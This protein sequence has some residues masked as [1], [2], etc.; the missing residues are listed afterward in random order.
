MNF[1]ILKSAVFGVL[2]M[3]VAGSLFAADWYV[4]P[5]GKNKA[6]GN[7]PAAPFKNIWKAIDKAKPGDTIRIAEGKYFGKMQCGWIAVNKPVNLIGGYSADFKTRNPLVHKTMLQPT[8]DM[9]ATKPIFG[10]LTI[11][12]TGQKGNVVVD[13]FVFDHTLANSY[14]PTKGK[15]AGFKNGMWLQPPAKGNTKFPSIDRYMLHSEFKYGTQGDLIIQNCL[16]LN[17]SNY[18]VNANHFLGSVK[19][20]NNV[21]IGGRMVAAEVRKSNAKDFM[22][23]YEFAYNTVMFTWTRTSEM[24]DMG[25]GVRANEGIISNIHNNIFGLNCMAGFDNTKGKDQKKK[26]KLDN[27]IFFLNKKA[28]VAITMSPNIKFMK[29]DGGG[30]DDLEE[31]PGFESVDKNISLKDP[32]LFKGILDTSYLKEFLNATYTEK[33]SYD[34]NSPVNTFREALGMNKQGSIKSKVSMFANPYPEA[35]VMKF[36]GAVPKYGAQI[37]AK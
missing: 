37:P 1:S 23:N 36:F 28:D 6:A 27:N 24:T 26:I 15:P 14:H 32:K 20:I 18:A 33:T 5:K 19:I 29:V 2:T 4:S 22:V 9:N 7:T 8:N 17:A 34:P 10:T 30:F 13:G 11:T 3:T 25:Y 31:A 12:I 16:F 35:N 21:F